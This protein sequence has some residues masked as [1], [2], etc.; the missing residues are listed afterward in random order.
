[1][2]LSE[3]QKEKL[4]KDS[5]QLVTKGA[6]SIPLGPKTTTLRLNNTWCL[7]NNICN[8]LCKMRGATFPA[9]KN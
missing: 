2:I 9:N 4:K 3:K 8:L 1:M 6:K 7:G 5:E